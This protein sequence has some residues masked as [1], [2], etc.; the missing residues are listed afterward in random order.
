MAVLLRRCR[1]SPPRDPQEDEDRETS[2]STAKGQANSN[3]SAPTAAAAPINH[4]RLQRPKHGLL[5]VSCRDTG[6]QFLVDGGSAVTLWPQSQPLHGARPVNVTLTSASGNTIPTFGTTRGE[7]NLGQEAGDRLLAPMW[8]L[9]QPKPQDNNRFIC[10]SFW[11]F[12]I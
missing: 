5:F 12:S 8:R 10:H 7:I 2:S 9:P 11:N 3:A 6:R 1:V 4:V